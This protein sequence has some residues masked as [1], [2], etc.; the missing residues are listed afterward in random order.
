MIAPL[1]IGAEVAASPAFERAN[2]ALLRLDERLKSSPFREGYQSRSDF[3]EA[4]ANL[5]MQGQLVDLEDL[6]LLDANTNHKIVDQA[7]SHAWMVL[8]ARRMVARR[9]IDWPLSDE[10][11]LGLERERAGEADGR[12]RDEFI[13]EP[14]WNESERLLAWRTAISEVEKLPAL[15]AAAVAWDQWLRLEPIQ[16]GSWR[17]GLMAAV[18]LRSKGKTKHHLAALDFGGRYA[19][20]RRAHHHQPYE[21]IIGFLEWIET[22]ASAG[23]KELDR[24]ALAHRVMSLK[25]KGR[26]KNSRLGELVDLFISHP[27][28]TVPMAAKALRVTTRAVDLMMR[29][30]GSVPRELTGRGRYKAWGIL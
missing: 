24:L 28:V 12:Q 27:V 9:A 8:R 30:I 6:V 11:I 3:R 22:A 26:R 18:I 21:R 29:D 13:Y 5:W 25:L 14:G 7:T 10:G 16:R 1:R 15:I 19:K 4:C 20:Y 23:Y 17:A 2:E